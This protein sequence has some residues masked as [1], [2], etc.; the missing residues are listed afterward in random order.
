M[1][2]TQFTLINSDFMLDCKSI[3]S[4]DLS[5]STQQNIRNI[6]LDKYDSKT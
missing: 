5:N 4:I 6:A 3:K 2:L 1:G